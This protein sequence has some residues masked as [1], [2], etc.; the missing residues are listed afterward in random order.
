MTSR[1]G[2]TLIEV[3]VAASVLGIAASALF[4]LLSK[5]LFNLRKVEDLHRYELVAE[6]VMNRMLMSST[7]SAPASAEG[8]VDNL[9]ARWNVRISPWAP[10]NLQGNPDEAVFRIDVRVSWQGRSS[11]PSINIEALKVAKVD[12]SNYDLLRVIE[13]AYPR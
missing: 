3:L 4:G 12:Y 5:S 11:R 9:G 1:R 10:P 8:P 6:D 7:L 2:F 13:L